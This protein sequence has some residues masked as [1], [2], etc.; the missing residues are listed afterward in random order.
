M[1]ES[2][3][4]ISLTLIV[5]NMESRDNFPSLTPQQ[6][7]VAERK[8]RT[9]QEMARCMLGYL[10]SLLWGEAIN[11][12]IH[13][14]NR[15]PMKV[16]EGKTPYEVWIGKKSNIS[17]FRV[18]GCDAYTFVILEKRKRLAKKYKKCIFVGYDNKHQGYMLYQPSTRAV[19]MS[20]DVKF[21]ELPN[22]SISSDHRN[23]DDDSSIAPN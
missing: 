10:P 23:D 9:I 11:T 5:P 19:F 13:I 7:G 14:L 3:I 4:A 6:N 2:I 16:V 22:E 21:D 18:F 15:C 20:R 12:T 17:H 1:G 8:N